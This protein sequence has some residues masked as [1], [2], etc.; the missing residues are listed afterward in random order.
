MVRTL[1]LLSITAAS[2]AGRCAELIVVNYASRETSMPTGGALASVVCPGL[3]GKPGL[4]VAD[5]SSPLPFILNGFEVLVNA[6]P[7]PLLAVHIP[8]AGDP[9]PAQIDFQVP[10][11]RNYTATLGVIDNGTVSVHAVS[12]VDNSGNA[13]SASDP[14]LR[15][16]PPAGIG[17]FFSIGNG[18]AS[19]QHALDNS[20]VTLDSPTHAGETI[21]VFANDFYQVWPPPPIGVPVPQQTLFQYDSRLPT[22]TPN[23]AFDYRYLYLQYYPTP[24]TSIPSRLGDSYP[25]G[26]PVQILSRGLVAN[27]IGVEEIH[28]VVPPDQPP[29]DWALFFNT[30]NYTGP[31]S[32]DLLSPRSSSYVLLPVR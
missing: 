22:G 19:A 23:F 28:F 14:P 8:D 26:Q 18:Y 13:I 2:F 27:Q 21:I 11:E 17:G 4:Y 25:A 20:F 1:V 12:G 31:H 24:I 15:S 32:C 10:I 29:G 6:F 3:R 9:M 30:C 7:A 5:R 16:L